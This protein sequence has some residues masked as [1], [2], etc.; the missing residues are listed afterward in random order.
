M[1]QTLVLFKKLPYE[2]YLKDLQAREVYRA[3]MNFLPGGCYAGAALYDASAQYSTR[4]YSTK[5]TTADTCPYPNDA[6]QCL[7]WEAMAT[8]RKVSF[9]RPQPFNAF[10]FLEVQGGEGDAFTELVL[11]VGGPDDGT[12]DAV[13]TDQGQ[14]YIAAA[15]LFGCGA[16]NTVFE[17]LAESHDRLLE[18][19]RRLTDTRIVKQHSVGRLAPHDAF[20]FGEDNGAG[21]A[22]IAR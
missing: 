13:V 9:G 2:E 6:A 1:P 7:V 10:V 14:E 18:V 15:N 21:A 19:L 11:D 16:Y 3:A 4:S 12:T 5:S 20:G 22:G 8:V 17:V